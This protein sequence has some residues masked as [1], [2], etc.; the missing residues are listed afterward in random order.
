MLSVLPKILLGVGLLGGTAGVV[1]AFAV[2]RKRSL[3][4]DTLAHAALPGICLAYL[5]FASRDLLVLSLGA[6]AAGLVGVLLVTLIPS[7]TRTREDAALG[8]VLSTFF[9]AGVVLL[10]VVEGNKAGLDAYLFGEVASLTTRDIARV[11][12]MGA[13]VLTVVALFYKELK[14]LAF[15]ESFAAAQGWPTLLIDLGLM[16]AIAAVTVFSLPLC[17]VILIAAI[18]IFPCTTARFWSHRL[19][20]VLV[21]SG[22]LGVA[23]AVG[24]VLATR[25][26]G[27]V[28]A[29]LLP[30]S[31]AAVSSPSLP[32]GPMIVL[33]SAAVLVV[34]VLVAPERGLLAAAWR[35][36]QTRR[37]VAT[38]H[39][40]RQL[41]EQSEDQLPHR[42]AIA[43]ADL[44]KAM[45]EDAATLNLTLRDL[46]RRGLIDRP[47]G[48]S[49]RLTEA[50]LQQAA[51]V[52]RVHRLWELFLVTDAGIADDHVHRDADDLEHFLPAELIK[53]LEEKL[54][55]DGKL[56][57]ELVTSDQSPVT[58]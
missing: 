45:H 5:L 39:V 17:G 11:A 43:N 49:L 52:T 56:P 28:I 58:R 24:G 42:P 26:P 25:A 23:C 57:G 50:G 46:R 4:G 2:L 37:Q 40:L 44:R 18:L 41:W 53:T 34:S 30:E 51:R 10:S 14:L 22:V 55:A 8:L 3:I 7:W 1:G 31:K 9:G 20:A 27:L 38:E 32:P 12:V 33:T 35:R 21:L 29:L 6:L 54:A 13:V 47:D 15:D 19:G 16:A 48:H 36:V